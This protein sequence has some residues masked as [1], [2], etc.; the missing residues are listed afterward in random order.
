MHVLIT[1]MLAAAPSES[2][3]PAE[4]LQELECIREWMELCSMRRAAF[5]VLE[6]S[7][8]KVLV[9]LDMMSEV[10]FT[11]TIRGKVR[12]LT[13]KL[14]DQVVKATLTL[15]GNELVWKGA[16]PYELELNKKLVETTDRYIRSE[17]VAKAKAPLVKKYVPG[18]ECEGL[19]SV[20]TDFSMPC[21]NKPAAPAPAQK[22]K[23]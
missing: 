4:Q 9:Q 21:I 19:G 11:A 1:L 13:A 8:D 3:V 5:P 10:T 22:K 23:K 16:D 12:E 15:E 20:K 18:G 17:V 6:V 7:D 2:W 14:G